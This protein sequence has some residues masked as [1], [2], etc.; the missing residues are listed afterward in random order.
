MF[1]AA[2]TLHRIFDEIVNKGDLDAADE[3]FADDFI[4]HGPGGELHGREEFKAS[5]AQWRDAV[6]D[7]HTEISNIIVDGDTAAWLVHGTGTHTGDGLGFPATNKRFDTVSA[8]L[9]RFVD[10]KAVEH[11]SEQGMFSMLVQLGVIPAP[12]A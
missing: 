6:P 3:L 2:A 10:G 9:A 5:I 8:N 12:T 4:D 1:D 11:W 7:V